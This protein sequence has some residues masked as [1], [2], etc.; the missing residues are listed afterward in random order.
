MRS[1]ARPRRTLC[2]GAPSQPLPFE[3]RRDTWEALGGGGRLWPLSS[4]NGVP[5]GARG[6]SREPA[7]ITVPCAA[8]GVLGRRGASSPS[9]IPCPGT[10]IHQAL[11][12]RASSPLPEAD[13]KE[14]KKEGGSLE[15]T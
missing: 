1:W 7:L 12:Q 15:L 3:Q 11:A 2:P 5:G 13:G 9:G 10:M 6:S 4:I 8:P 14:K